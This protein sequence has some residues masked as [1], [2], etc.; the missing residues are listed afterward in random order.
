MDGFIQLPKL[1]SHVAVSYIPRL[2]ARVLG[3]NKLLALTKAFGG[4]HPIVVREVFYQLMNI[5]LCLQFHDVF[6]FHLSPYQFGVVV[7]GGCETMVHCI[8][9]TLDAHPNWVVHQVDI[10]IIFNTIS[11]KAIFQELWATRRQLS[12]LFLIVRSFYGLWVPLYFNYHSSSMALFI[13]ISY[14]GIR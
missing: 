13:I 6:V 1:G 9:A 7:R 12:Q 10:V 3:E 4:I 2:V 5:A 11:C 14:V 8:Q